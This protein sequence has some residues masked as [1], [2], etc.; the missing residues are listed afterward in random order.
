MHFE[1]V[2]IQNFR[3]IK[4]L[5]LD[6]KPGINILIGDNGMGKTTALEAMVV[7]LGSYLLGVP[8]ILSVGIQQ[9]DFREEVEIIAG[10]SKQKTYYSPNILFDLNLGGKTYSGSRTR[11]DRSGKGRT[12]TV[13]GQISGY[14]QELTEKNGSNLP[15][16]MYMGI[17]RVVAAKRSDFGKTQKNMLD[18]RRCGYVGCLDS[19]IDKNSI[20][21]WVKKMAY[22]Q[23]LQ[24]KKMP[25]Y[26]FF[27]STVSRI[28]QKMNDLEEVPEIRYSATH[29]T[30]TYVENGKDYPLGYWSAGYQSLL[31]MVMDIT[32]RIAL[33]N[34]EIDTSV[35]AEGIV[36]IDEIDMHLHPKWQWKILN[37]LEE[38]FPKI[39][40]IVATHSPVIIASNKDAN[41]IQ[42]VNCTEAIRKE[43]AY[44]YPINS[45]LTTRQDSVDML[46]EATEKIRAFDRALSDEKFETAYDILQEMIKLFG[47]DNPFVIGAQAD[48]DLAFF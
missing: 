33:L 26:E 3:G 27:N 39:Q 42:L 44:A 35:N 22:E 32:F 18:D 40:F 46:P 34:P 1:S 48:Y 29:G 19:M 28:M 2:K 11:T 12:R 10:A 9:D 7:A 21:E 36:L 16:L 17:S 37:V 6:L 38:N 13:S 45:V 25:E 15:V 43:S 5:E 30:V 14:A 23:A 31:W 8:K 47:K 4:E 41:L 20:I 24:K